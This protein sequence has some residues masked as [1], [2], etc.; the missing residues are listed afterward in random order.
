MSISMCNDYFIA[1]DPL[2]LLLF[3]IPSAI[4]EQ[5]KIGSYG[6]QAGTG[7]LSSPRRKAKWFVLSRITHGIMM[8]PQK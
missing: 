7:R 1:W 8:D 2:T 4:I 3:A 5:F 6:R